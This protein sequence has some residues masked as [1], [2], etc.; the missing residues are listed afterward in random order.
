MGSLILA[1]FKNAEI[2]K[3]MHP[4]LKESFITPTDFFLPSPFPF[5]ASTGP[6]LTPSPIHS[7]KFLFHSC[8]LPLIGSAIS[9]IFFL[10]L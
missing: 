2:F 8:S 9:G 6:V 10:C 7:P 1:M 4:V 3:T 5:P